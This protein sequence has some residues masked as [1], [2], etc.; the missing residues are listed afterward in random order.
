M[1]APLHRFSE[2]VS[3][4]ETTRLLVYGGDEPQERSTA[5]VVPWRELDQELLLLGAGGS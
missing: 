1:L 2:V 3:P 5:T 4:E